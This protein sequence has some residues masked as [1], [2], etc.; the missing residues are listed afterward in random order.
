[1]AV[2]GRRTSKPLD[3][4][5]AQTSS[6]PADGNEGKH[7]P[8]RRTATAAES[9]PDGDRTVI[10]GSLVETARTGTAARIAAPRAWE[11]HAARSHV[12]GSGGHLSGD[13]GGHLSGNSTAARIRA[14]A[15]CSF[16]AQPAV[17]LPVVGS[18]ALSQRPGRMWG[19]VGQSE[20]SRWLS[21]LLWLINEPDQPNG[22]NVNEHRCALPWGRMPSICFLNL[23]SGV[24]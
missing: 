11:P 3:A 16:S 20:V 23:F 21:L 5:K 14:V 24:P 7:P 9:E 19:A 4:A 8:E 17:S 12:G 13:G 6:R 15:P 18:E 10:T 2:G 22:N 1:M